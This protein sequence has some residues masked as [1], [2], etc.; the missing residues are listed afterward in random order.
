MA[1]ETFLSCPATARVQF[2][3]VVHCG[4]P[5][6]S[7]AH[8]ASPRTPIVIAVTSDFPN[9]FC[10]DSFPDR[11][12][13]FISWVCETFHLTWQ[14]IPQSYEVHLCCCYVST[15]TATLFFNSICSSWDIAYFPTHMMYFKEYSGVD[16]LDSG[17]DILA[18][19]LCAWPRK[20]SA[21]IRCKQ[22]LKVM[23][24]VDTLTTFALYPFLGVTALETN[25]VKFMIW[26]YG[27]ISLIIH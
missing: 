13:L 16:A 6:G 7:G 9:I 15:G 20:L 8:Q 3:F 4:S 22:A 1:L 14:D 23:C 26:L 21:N 19:H 17:A 5:R 18:V 11:R 12:V 25:N 10:T 27:C 2:N 24:A